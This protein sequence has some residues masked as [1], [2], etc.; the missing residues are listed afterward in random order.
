MRLND[1]EF[2]ENFHSVVIYRT[3]EGTKLHSCSCLA[4]IINW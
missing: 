3:I 2:L 4:D 1:D